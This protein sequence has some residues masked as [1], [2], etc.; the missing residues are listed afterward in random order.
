L[1]LERL[2]RTHHCFQAKERHQQTSSLTSQLYL[3]FPSS[4]SYGIIIICS[5]REAIDRILEVENKECL[6]YA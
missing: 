2:S 6:A 4:F 3:I 1:E 5:L